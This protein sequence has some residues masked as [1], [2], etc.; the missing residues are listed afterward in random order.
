MQEEMAAIE[1]NKTWDLIPLSLEKS[2]GYHWVYTVKLN[3]NGSRARLRE[4]LVTKE[5]SQIY[6][7][8]TTKRPPLWLN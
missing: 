8:L 2:D 4:R 7:V 6:I 1:Q 5:Y 3:L